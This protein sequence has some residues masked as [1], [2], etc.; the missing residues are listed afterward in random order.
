MSAYLLA[1]FADNITNK[2]YLRGLSDLIKA[3]DDPERYGG[4]Y[5]TNFLSSPIPNVVGYVR[6]Y[7]DPVVRDVRGLQDALMNKIPGMSKSLPPRRNV[8][9]DPIIYTPG[10]AP[11]SLGKIGKVFSPARK[12][13]ITNDLVFNEFQRVGYAPSMPQRSI[14]R[15][16]LTSEQYEYMLSLQQVYRTKE[17]MEDE[18][19]SPL[20]NTYTDF[21]KQEIFKDI[22]QTNQKEARDETFFIFPEIEQ[23]YNTLKEKQSDITQ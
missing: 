15:V 1:S 7:D 3:I 8:F 2:T 18:I 16:P 17:Q 12:S 13:E 10:A 23:K 11:E 6:R 5:I 20:W 4:R 21:E 9:G 19:K 22:L 14:K